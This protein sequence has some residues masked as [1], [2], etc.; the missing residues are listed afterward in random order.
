MKPAI[1]S[2]LLSQNDAGQTGGH[3]AGILIPKSGGILDFFPVLN[4]NE[5]NPR[6]QIV[7]TDET[8]RKWE[9]NFIYYNSKLFGGTRNEYRLT[10]MTFYIHQNNLK[11]VTDSDMV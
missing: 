5:K 6:I 9:F 7:F 4:I 2:K 11:Q 8:D 10:G 1:I 3:Q